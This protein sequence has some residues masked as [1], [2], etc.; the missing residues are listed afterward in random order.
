METESKVLTGGAMNLVVKIGDTVHRTVKGHPMLHSYLLY[1][2]KAGMPTVPRFLGLDETGREVLTYLKGKTMGPDYP[3][4]HPCLHSDETIIDM[5]CFMRK[6]HDVSVGF[7]PEAVK[8]SWENPYF[9]NESYETI[10]HGDAAIWNFTFVDERVAGLFDFDQA[11]PGTRAWDLT[12]TV[13]SAVGLTY[14]IYDPELNA[15]EGYEPGKHAAE[16]KRCVKLF[17]DAYGMDCPANFMELVALRM[18][19]IC[20][21]IKAGVVK[22]VET[23]VQMEKGGGLTHYQKIAE[24]VRDHGKE[25]I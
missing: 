25:W 8:N 2:E 20:E 22:G 5:A 24:H 23:Y 4:H 17:F 10:C 14:F 12:I 19:K 13:F 9:P 15:S 16:R 21:S 3:P 18:E 1:L 7:L 11:Y 6:L